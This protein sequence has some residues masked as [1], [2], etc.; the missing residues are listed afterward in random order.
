MAD[1]T[2]DQRI[3]RTTPTPSHEGSIVVPTLELAGIAG[4][5]TMIA[6]HA[7]ELAGKV[8]EVAYLGF[9]Y[10]ALIAA[11]FVAVVL[12]AVGDRRGWAL[13]GAT[14]AATLI[15]YV[16]TRTTGLPG[17][18]DDVGNWGETLAIW[19]MLA[20]I[21]VCGMAAVALQRPRRA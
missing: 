7:T 21:G 3:G 9:G 6:I 20:E 18:T 19:S 10:V 13:A 1:T 15:G 14:A 12:L 4:L 16:L 17:S 11:S 2:T 5:A 8:E